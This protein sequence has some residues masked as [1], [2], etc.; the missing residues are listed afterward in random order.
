MAINYNLKETAMYYNE[1]KD[2][3]L[4]ALGFG[5]MRLPLV[6]GGCGGDID[7]EKFGEMVKYAIEHGVN[8]F[9]TAVPYHDSKSETAVGK[10]LSAYPRE[11]F[12][13]ATKYPGHQIS[14]SYNPEKTFSGQLKRCGVD[15]FDFYLMHN[16]NENSL[17]TYMNPKWGILD[18]FREQKEQGRI[19]HLGFSTHGDV[20]CIK[21]FLDAYG[22]IMEFCQIQLN[23]LDWTL[24]DAKSKCEFL[25]SRG[26]PIWVMESVRGGRL[27]SFDEE[28]EAEMKAMNPEKSIASW[29]Y[30]WL[31]GVEGVT[32]VL[33]GMSN[34][35]QM[36]DNVS[37]FES[38][39]PLTAEETEEA[40]KVAKKLEAFVPCTGC[41]YCCDGCPMEL[42][43]PKIIS[44]Y[45]DTKVHASMNVAMRH[46]AMGASGDA[47][48][49]IGCGQCAAIC[50]QKIKVPELMLTMDE[51]FKKLPSWAEICRKREAE[52]KELER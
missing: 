19:R 40:F 9:D 31:Q 50:P 37:T 24:Q 34:I 52:Q 48:R 1:F 16:V 32:V 12:Y 26:I 17:E 20:P 2:L 51:A 27:A 8:Y 38:R 11:S 14:S 30:R 33:S 44:L 10:A 35:D 46:D 45:N 43:I 42:N 13:L 41:R 39:N 3:K 6:P 47:S 5:T 4:S 49:C 21:E 28:T 23:Y 22:D 36:K 15:Y 18:Y 29:G 25:N 7:E